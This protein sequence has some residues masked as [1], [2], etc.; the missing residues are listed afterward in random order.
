M[1]IAHGVSNQPPDQ[2]YLVPMV[3]RMLESGAQVPTGFLADSG[4]FSK[5]NVEHLQK[6]C[7]LR[8]ERS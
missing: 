8:C 2:G 6:R 7:G 1:I 3:E 5:D 4:Y